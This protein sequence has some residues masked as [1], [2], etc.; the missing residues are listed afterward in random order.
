MLDY[1]K[2]ENLKAHL[3]VDYPGKYAMENLPAGEYRLGVRHFESRKNA[4]GSPWMASQPRRLVLEPGQR[5]G[6]VFAF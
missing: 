2:N 3:W 5:P 6:A 1:W 4:K